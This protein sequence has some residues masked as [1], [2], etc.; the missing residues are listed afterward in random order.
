MSCY[1]CMVL[2]KRREE[3][4]RLS[5]EDL[6]PQ[7]TMQGSACPVPD[8]LAIPLIKNTIPTNSHLLGSIVLLSYFPFRLLPPCCFPRSCEK[9]LLPQSP[10]TCLRSCM[11]SVPHMKDLLLHARSCKADRKTKAA[12]HCTAAL[13]TVSRPGISMGGRQHS[14][15]TCTLHGRG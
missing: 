12:L 10:C 7:S 1:V 8:A 13:V 2:R 6:R 9:L 11:T 14:T 5:A 15:T 3:T 4:T